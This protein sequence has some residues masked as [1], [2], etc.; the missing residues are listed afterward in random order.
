MQTTDLLK[1]RNGRFLTFGLLY[2]S[3]GIPQ[4]FTG[5]AMIAYMRQQG[6]SLDQIGL[7]GAALVLPWAFKWVWAPL[8]DVIPLDEGRRAFSRHRREPPSY[9]LALWASIGWPHFEQSGCALGRRACQTFLWH[10]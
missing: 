6:M 7:F 3:Q 4:G 10:D 2:V 1:T 8:I 9:G 5:V